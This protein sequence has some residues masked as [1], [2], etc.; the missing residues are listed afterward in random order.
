MSRLSSSKIL[1]KN[2]HNF[3]VSGPKNYIPQHPMLRPGFHFQEAE[4]QPDPPAPHETMSDEQAKNR[5]MQYTREGLRQIRKR[6]LGTMSEVDEQAVFR[7]SSMHN[8]YMVLNRILIAINNFHRDEYII[9]HLKYYITEIYNPASN[10]ARYQTAG[11]NNVTAA[12]LK[13]AIFKDLCYNGFLDLTEDCE[14]CL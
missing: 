11:T 14:L 3:I 12:N 9:K 6:K 4:P 5:G 13:C 8:L 7:D 10:W 1:A 2:P